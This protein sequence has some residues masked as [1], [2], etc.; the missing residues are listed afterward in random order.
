LVRIRE[1]LGDKTFLKDINVLPP[2]SI[3]IYDFQ[4][5]SIEEYWDYNFKPD[6]AKSEDEFV[7][8]LVKKFKYSVRRR[9]EEPNYKYGV[10]LSGGLDSRVIVAAMEKDKRRNVLSF[11]FG[12]LDCD[13]VK[14]AKKVSDKANT[15]FKAIE[16]SP[17]TIINNA[18]KEAFYTDGLDYIGVSYLPPVL[19][20]IKDEVDVVFDGFAFDM[21]LGGSF[22]D[23]QILNADKDGIFD[24]IYSKLTFFSKEELN[25]LFRNEYYEIIKYLPIESFKK[26]FY[27]I[28][29]DLFPNFS[30]KF[31]LRNH[32]RRRTL[33]GH[34]LMRVITENTVPTLDNDLIDLINTIPPELRY[35]HTIYR[36]FLS[37]IS[38]ELAIIPYDKT[39]VSANAPPTL[40]KIG[41][42]FQLAKNHGKEA[43]SKLSRGKIVIPK[44]SSYVD[45]NE[46]FKTNENWKK[47]FRDLLLTEESVS[48]I[49]LDQNYVKKLIEDNEKGKSDNAL[50]IMFIASFELFL[51]DIYIPISIM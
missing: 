29:E 14:I 28:N 33:G 17:E 1:I 20:T 37:K 26:E 15:K 31:V 16:I 4:D 43:I 10:S 41:K 6:Y 23:K 51:R 9:M 3:L 44:K 8:E 49:Y 47:Y 18:D 34:V 24:L 5:L 7:D 36:K 12:P 46:W 11:S 32:V 48:K 35:S 38:P 39:M 19:R 30:D 13:E 27:S 22:L 50:K 45:F 21:I 25:K 42:Y 2:A 40:W